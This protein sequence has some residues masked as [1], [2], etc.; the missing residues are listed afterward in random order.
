M[1]VCTKHVVGDESGGDKVYIQVSG[2]Q[3]ALE[4]NHQ[5]QFI[6]NVMEEEHQRA[7]TNREST[8]SHHKLIV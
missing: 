2:N 8:I 3:W 6:R 7:I 4:R 1:H 5:A